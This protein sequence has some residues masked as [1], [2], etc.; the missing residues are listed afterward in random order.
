MTN[1][2]REIRIEKLT[3]NVGTGKEQRSLEKGTILIKHLTGSEPVKTITNKRIPGWGLRPGLPIGC[4]LTL[5]DSA[6]IKDLISRF[7]DAK[8]KSLD[9]RCFDESGNIS[10]GVPEYIDI[11]EVDYNPEIGIMGFQVS[12]TL[13]RRGFR[14]KRRSNKTAKVPAHHLIGKEEAI[15]FMKDTFGIK[16]GEE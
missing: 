2:M 7:L 14:I 8:G 10:F 1:P 3:L 16:V 5:R 13:E 11:P 4:K 15:A 9:P 12:I 6:K